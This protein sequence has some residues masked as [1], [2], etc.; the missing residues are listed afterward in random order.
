MEVTTAMATLDDMNPGYFPQLQAPTIGEIA[1]A[2]P[3]VIED[4]RRLDPVLSAV[5]FGS[6]L[7]MPEL[8]ANC[9]RIQVLVHLSLLFGE[10][11]G[12]PTEEFV[13]RQFEE[14]GGG[15][16][17][18]MEDPAEDVFVSR[19]HTLRGN[20]FVLEGLMEG[21]GFYFQRL[22]EVVE[23]MPVRAPFDRIRK[24]V[25]SLLLASD[26]IVRRSGIQEVLLGQGT[27]LDRIPEEVLRKLPVG[28]S[29]I[30]LKDSELTGLGL[31][32]DE[33]ADFIFDLGDRASL[34]K[35]SMNN[36]LLERRPLVRKDDALYFVLPTEVATAAIR[37]LIETVESIGQGEAFETALAH[38]YSKVLSRARI[39]GT[40]LGKKFGFVKSESGHF[41]SMLTEF[42]AGRFLHLIFIVDGLEGFSEDGLSGLNARPEALSR[43]IQKHISASSEMARK[44]EGFRGGLSLI[45]S[46]GFGRGF[47]MEFQHRLGPN[48]RLESIAVYDLLTL[49]WIPEF[50]VHSLWR[51]LD[52]RDVLARNGV[53]LLNVNGLANLVAWAQ[54]LDGHLVPHG[55]LPAEFGSGEGRS[56]VVVP[57]DALRALRHQVLTIWDTRRV[58]DRD[59]RW[60]KVFKLDRSEFEE[61]HAAPLYGSEDDVH[62]QKLRAVYL[63]EGRSWW[64]GI[65]APTD[66]PGD[67][68]FEHWHM[69]GVWMKRFAPILEDA[70]RSLP[71]GPLAIEVA[72]AEIVGITKVPVKSPI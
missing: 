33:F 47:G 9:F 28:A 65:S 10:G 44:Q 69:L 63:T 4:L 37:F 8:Q 49:S 16:C 36:T 46:C 56:M 23:G 29:A 40:R 48:W 14:L 58:E 31:R 5:A 45:V 71:S 7:I 27:P 35:Q 25:D 38:E 62:E 11:T 53:S 68:V 24:S 3:Q 41:A 18:R 50:D 64:I 72:F 51:L 34:G 12:A 54:R 22:L 70:Y 66:S 19:V 15:V 13:A 26:L 6:L 21:A 60:T 43:I 17:G 42:D 59:K 61:D 55:E 1:A 20:F 39:L 57:Q 30:Q 32:A 52:G 67:G 2:H